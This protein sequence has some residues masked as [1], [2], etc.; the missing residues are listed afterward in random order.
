MLI[1]PGNLVVDARGVTGVS[2]SALSK[3][4]DH[5]RIVS[6]ATP[7]NGVELAK[8]LGSGSRSENG[9]TDLHVMAINS[10][11]KWGNTLRS[12]LRM[13]DFNPIFFG[14]GSEKVLRRVFLGIVN[15]VQNFR[16]RVNGERQS[17][18]KG[19]GRIFLG[20]N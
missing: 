16:H 15:P 2:R 3:E 9:V 6:R 1:H 10:P 8:D 20:C 19:H 12:F 11:Q 4:T 5:S 17:C 18:A 13:S 14:C 7:D